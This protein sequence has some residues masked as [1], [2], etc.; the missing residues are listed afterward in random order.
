MSYTEIETK[1]IADTIY[2]NGKVYTVDEEF[3]IADSFA[4]YQDR[5]IA[6]GTKEQVMCYMG[7]NTKI[8]D[9]AGKTVLPGL[10]DSHLH[11][12]SFG[13][14]KMKL[15]CMN[16]SKEEI[17][18]LVKEAC[19]AAAPGE[20]VEGCGW[21]QMEWDEQIFPTKEDLDAVSG[22][23]PVYLM[24]SCGHAAWANSKAFAIAGIN[25]N[26]QNPVGGEYLRKKDGTL[27]GVVTDQAQ[28]PFNKVLP[29]DNE[30]KVRKAMKLA[31]ESFFENGIT[32]VGDAGSSEEIYEILEDMY[33]ENELKIR[34]YMS[35]RCPG[36]PDYQELLSTSKSYMSHGLR[37]GE[38]NNHLTSRALKISADGSLGACSAWML[39]P[40]SDNPE[41]CGNG[42][43]SY[44]ELY[45][46]V[47]E[48][49]K[50]GFQV[51]VHAIGDAT[52]KQCLDV[53][54][55]VIKELPDSDHR[56][57]IE[58]AQICRM[59][60][61]K[62][63]KKL[64]VIPTMQ[65][66]FIGVASLMADAHLGDRVAGSYAWRTFIEDG[67]VIPNGTD[68]PVEPINPFYSLYSAVTRKGAKLN[69]KEGWYEEQAMTREEALKSYT[70]WSA[71]GAFE[72][73]IK[74]SIETGKLADFVI[75][76]KDY[77]EC[78]EEEIKDIKVL[79]TISGGEVVYQNKD[80]NS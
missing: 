11:M 5:F 31:E 49:R 21:N 41:S 36:R 51:W 70:I 56:C 61:I 33:R 72:E 27:L 71:Y 65:T 20:W 26:V 46:I 32:S 78:M 55:R 40:Y 42:K 19:E 52:N 64:G 44:D 14:T 37:I 2:L 1:L 17:L 43:L 6:A 18:C 62:R 8:V 10:I 23:V 7:E 38:F 48:A 66:Q 59:E 68:A 80:V 69:Q 24:R 35:L 60:D 39:E 9:L 3:H 53:Y 58:H 13:I 75:I 74:G 30:E 76:D 57:R 63:F 77:M 54:E 50:A 79:A 12:V 28:E 45:E 15:D 67:N 34:I 25:E 73:K 4:V 16:K 22:D 29:K 47:K